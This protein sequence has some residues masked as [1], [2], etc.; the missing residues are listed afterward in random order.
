MNCKGNLS[1]LT[2]IDASSNNFQGQ[3]PETV[4]ELSSLRLLNLSN[5]AFTAQIPPSMGNLNHLEALDLSLNK[6]SGKIPEQLGRLTFLN[7][8]NF[9]YNHLEGRIPGG[10]QIQTFT[11]SSFAGNDGICGFPLNQVYKI[12][13]APAPSQ[14]IS[15]EKKAYP[16]V[17]I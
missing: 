8:L 12:I 3:I 4:G 2:S 1:A 16:V 13:T 7:F 5:N 17:D 6:L 10:K 9:S 15:E 14:Q 11:E